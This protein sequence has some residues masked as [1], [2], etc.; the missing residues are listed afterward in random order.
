MWSIV[1]EGALGLVDGGWEGG[2]ERSEVGTAQ[3]WW[4]GRQMRKRASSLPRKLSAV[5]MAT[6]FTHFLSFKFSLSAN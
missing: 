5:Y 1:L 4:M 3:Y 2:D 6:S